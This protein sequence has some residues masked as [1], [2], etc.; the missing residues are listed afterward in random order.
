MVA[1]IADHFYNSI[2]ECL[3]AKLGMGISFVGS[4][5]LQSLNKRDEGK[6]AN[7]GTPNH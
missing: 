6:S 5:I 1:L 3:P 2:C 7:N 4:E